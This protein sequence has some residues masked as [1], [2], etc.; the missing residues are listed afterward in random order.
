VPGDAIGFRVK[1]GDQEVTMP[2]P[3]HIIYKVIDLRQW[4]DT[5]DAPPSL[6]T[7]QQKVLVLI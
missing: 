5:E 7:N 6:Q 2:S 4:K 1:N 3:V